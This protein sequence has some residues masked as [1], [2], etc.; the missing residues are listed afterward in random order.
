M[1]WVERQFFLLIANTSNAVVN[2]LEAKSVSWEWN[3]LECTHKFACMILLVEK[4]AYNFHHI[5]NKVP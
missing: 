4:G 5:L 1:L 3:C 2:I